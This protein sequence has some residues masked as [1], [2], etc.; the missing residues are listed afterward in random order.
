MRRT[1]GVTRTKGVSLAKGP[2]GIIGLVLLAGGIL[3]FIFASTSFTADFPN[4]DVNGGTLFGIEGNGWTWLLFGGTGLVLLLSAPM[5][6]SAKSMAMLGGLVMLVA[7]VL[8]IVDGN[9][10]L[11]VFAA[12]RA[13]MLAF[14]VA[15]AAMLIVAMLPRVGK[16]RERVVEDDRAATTT[17]DGRF[18]RT[19]GRV[20]EPVGT[21]ERRV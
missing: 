12:N 7:C 9:D 17:G 8:A 21:T 14:G 10:V 20:D 3:G 11:G 4:G 5:H 2:V 1:E 15:A 6:W 18:A 13:T 19:D 16:R